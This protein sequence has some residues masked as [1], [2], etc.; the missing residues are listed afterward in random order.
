[1]PSRKDISNA[2][3]EATVAA[4]RFGQGYK[5]ISIHLSIHP[6]SSPHQDRVMGATGPGGK[7]Q[8][9][10]IIP[11]VRVVPSVS[12]GHFSGHAWKIFKCRHPWGH[13]DQEP[14]PL[15]LTLFNADPFRLC[16]KFPPDDRAPHPIFKAVTS[17]PLEES[18]FGRLYSGSR[19]FSHDSY[20]TLI[21]EGR[22]VGSSFFTTTDR[23]SVRISAEEAPIRLSITCSILP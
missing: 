19:S 3:K 17:Q 12:S 18:I 20:L 5:A 7:D 11:S 8:A 21:C 4:C 2:L 10:Y 15:Q 9:R 16:F 23:S 6:S 22:N 13:P 14:K 1:M